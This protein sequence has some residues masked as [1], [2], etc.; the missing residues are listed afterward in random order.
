VSQ[1]P[2]R[3]GAGAIERLRIL[4]ADGQ[5]ARLDHITRTV[6]RLGHEVARETRLV[7]V[8]AITRAVRPDAAIVIVE[9]SS[10]HSLDLIGRIVTE[11]AC[12][13]I[14]ILDVEDEAFVNKAA[15]RGIFAY[16]TQGEDPAALQSSLDVVL[17]RFAEYQGLEGA[18]ARR[19]IT[20]RA[21][22]ILME[23]HA[24]DEKQA[25]DRLRDQARRTNR[26]VTDIA[27]AVVLSVH[28]LPA[29]P[30]E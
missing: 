10:E 19:A 15:K 27:E 28:L 7:D 30:V 26:K 4:V 20:E 21:K 2:G 16:I 13:V 18:F 3:S 8:P 1:L 6:A 22:G 11:A 29:Q 24:I 12:P 25:F 23:R 5:G 9:E 14:A 17:R